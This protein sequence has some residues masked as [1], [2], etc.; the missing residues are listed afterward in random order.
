MKDSIG[1]IK[2]QIEEITLAEQQANTLLSELLQ[3][4]AQ[5]V[6]V[7][8]VW[9]ITLPDLF[10]GAWVNSEIID[11]VKLSALQEQFKTIFVE[12]YQQECHEIKIG[13][14][15]L[16]TLTTKLAFHYHEILPLLENHYQAWLIFSSDHEFT[17]SELTQDS[18][19]TSLSLSLKKI[20][21]Q[22][23]LE[24]Q[25]YYQ[26]LQQK[27]REAIYNCQN[28]VTISHRAIAQTCQGLNVKRG[29]V[30]RLNDS[31]S[32]FRDSSTSSFAQIEVEPLTQWAE[33]SQLETDLKAF[34]LSDSF[35]CQQIWKQAPT[36]V[37][38]SNQ[39]FS[40]HQ[41]PSTLTEP[42][43]MPA[44]LMI[45]IMGKTSNLSN[46]PS[47]LGLLLLQHDQ[48]RWWLEPEYNLLEGITR[49]LST[50]II[51]HQTRQQ[52]QS[53]VNE[54]TAN[55]QRNV[56]VQAKFY[57][58]SRQE[59]EK[60][61]QVN[62]LKDEF[63]STISHE[64][65]TPLATM[66]LAIQMLRRHELTPQRKEKYLNILAEEWKR[67]HNLIKDL[68]TLQNVEE[69]EFPLHVDSMQLQP[70]LTQLRDN[71]NQKWQEKG[72][73]CTIH[74]HPVSLEQQAITM[75][76]DTDKF[77]RICWELLTNAGKYATAHT[78]VS[79]VL[80]QPSQDRIGI[81]VTNL[82][83]GIAPAEQDVIFEK[84]RRGKGATQKAIPGTGAGLAVV[85]SLA[86]QLHGKIELD[87]DYN[88]TGVGKTT[89]YV[90]LPQSLTQVSTQ[91]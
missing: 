26:R 53:L 44:W 12:N 85:K 54:R 66:N 74:Y 33:T 67:E 65:Y 1:A 82:G 71:F 84:F 11:P 40:S 56:D 6:E 88:S 48:P 79:L 10:T 5:W 68:L 46:V 30:F 43:P 34:S 16:P 29:I 51:Q 69:Q 86:K 17:V 25:Q 61:Q 87:S 49:E 89:F 20:Q 22:Y 3:F 73:S 57:E 31:Q 27:V 18:L 58:A 60:L 2:Q 47:I 19:K 38:Q 8:A 37:A 59:L 45:P 35:C 52:V 75:K 36:P 72:L 14:K 62:Q 63:L 15:V 23:Y 50:S 9:L 78:E 90:T 80:S 91:G 4:L 55:L 64:L 24:Q 7:D 81:S 32:F 39:P 83:Y 13:D 70:M 41:E 21:F 28:L 76:T 77:Q 42:L